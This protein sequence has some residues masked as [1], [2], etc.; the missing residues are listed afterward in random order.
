MVAFDEVFQ[1]MKQDQTVREKEKKVSIGKVNECNPQNQTILFSSA[2][3]GNL[4]SA[5]QHNK[6]T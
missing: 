1:V 3:V 2:H 6:F 4:S 5:K